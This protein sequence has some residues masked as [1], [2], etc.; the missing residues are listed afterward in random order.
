MNRYVGE[1]HVE[2]NFTW[3]RGI[4]IGLEVVAGAL[5]VGCAAL[6]VM[7]LKRKESEV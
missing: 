2:W 4:Y 3:W 7:S 6:Y 1:V 5:M